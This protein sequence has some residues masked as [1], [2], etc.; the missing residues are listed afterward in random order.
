MAYIGVPKT[1]IIGIPE[2]ILPVVQ[3][4]PQLI[5]MPVI[6]PVKEPEKVPVRRSEWYEQVRAYT[7]RPEQ[8]RMVTR[9]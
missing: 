6:E 3:P 1:R 5:P 4:E 9:R 2:P 7:L 8:V